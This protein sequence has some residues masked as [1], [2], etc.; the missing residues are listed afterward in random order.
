MNLM[1]RSLEVEH[2]MGEIER[3]RMSEVEMS[4]EKSMEIMNIIRSRNL[5][6]I[7]FVQD[8]DISCI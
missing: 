7:S 2:M 4:T 6:V 8:M 5:T 1:V 3:V